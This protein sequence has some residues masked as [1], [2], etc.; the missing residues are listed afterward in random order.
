MRRDG[1]R[2]FTNQQHPE[3]AVSVLH[4]VAASLECT[5][6]S[7]Y[8]CTPVSCECGHSFC[9]NCVY[10]WFENKLNC[11]TCRTQIESKPILNVHLKHIG[12]SIIELLISTSDQEEA[13]RLKK[14]Q[15]RSIKYYENDKKNNNLFGDLFNVVQTLIDTSDGV[16]RCGYCHWEARGDVCERC[17]HTLRRG[18]NDFSDE[19]QHYEESEDLAIAIDGP[20]EYDSEDSFIDGRDD[21]D[22]LRDRR[23]SNELSDWDGFNEPHLINTDDE[24]AALSVD[25][26]EDNPEM[27]RRL[28]R[29]RRG[30]PISPTSSEES[31][32]RGESVYAE[33]LR[34]MPSG[35]EFYQYSDVEDALDRFHDEDV[36]REVYDVSD[37]EP[38]NSSDEEEIRSSSLSNR[39]RVID[40]SDDEGDISD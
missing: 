26:D 30:T 25:S 6:C 31:G 24:I 5:I 34:P 33:D 3:L 32:W 35:D 22:V 14:Q 13:K 8:M 20:N 17:G 28:S 11:P 4:K 2:A 36:N 39:R 23:N 16:P 29:P 19:D 40:I 37:V 10:S 1:A 9:Y 15:D 27:P 18:D 21:E 7:E 12:N 38:Y